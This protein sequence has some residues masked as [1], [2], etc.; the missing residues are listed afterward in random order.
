M[1]PTIT[2]RKKALGCDIHLASDLWSLANHGAM[3]SSLHA[4]LSASLSSR[5][6]SLSTTATPAAL[7][8]FKNTSQHSVEWSRSCMHITVR[9]TTALHAGTTGEIDEQVKISL[10]KRFLTHLH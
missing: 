9:K 3:Q 2:S 8:S 1:H 5:T 6:S 4:R 7:A 10:C